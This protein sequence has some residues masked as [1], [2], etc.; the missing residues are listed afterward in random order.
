LACSF[1]QSKEFRRKRGERL[2]QQQWF[3]VTCSPV[4]VRP[5]PTWP[6]Y[7]AVITAARRPIDVVPVMMRTDAFAVI[8]LVGDA[9]VDQPPR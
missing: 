1:K 9:K 4:R 7:F 2:L 3:H 8:T 5:E 6:D